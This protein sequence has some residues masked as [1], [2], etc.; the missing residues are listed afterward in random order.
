MFTHIGREHVCRRAN[1]SERIPIHEVVER[2]GENYGNSHLPRVSWIKDSG[3]IEGSFFGVDESQEGVAN[4]KAEKVSRRWELEKIFFEGRFEMKHF[5]GL[6]GTR[7]CLHGRP[8]VLREMY[9]WENQAASAV[10]AGTCRFI[11]LST[12]FVVGC[13]RVTTRL[14][15]TRNCAALDSIDREAVFI[16]SIS[17]LLPAQTET[18]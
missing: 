6:K 15:G 4:T 17:S 11:F 3:A 13:I 10:H 12:G 2:R 5:W 8:I 9:I 18:R 16:C 7:R 1:V 14:N